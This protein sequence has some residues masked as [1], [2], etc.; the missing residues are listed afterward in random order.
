MTVEVIGHQWFWEVRYPGT[1]AVTANEIHIPV[2]TR[3]NVVATTADVIHSFWVPELNRKI[4]MIPGRRTGRCS[5]PTGP[6]ATAASAREFCGLQHAH[7]S[8]Y[9]VRRSPGG[10][11]APGCAARQAAPA[12]PRHARWRSAGRAALHGQPV[13]ELPHDRAAPRRSGDD[14]PR[15]HPRGEPH[16]ARRR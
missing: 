7:M 1:A 9:V 5:T 11:S 3:V 8:L 15:P 10:A 16:H 12:L 6:G 4:D 2:G 14:R 13:R